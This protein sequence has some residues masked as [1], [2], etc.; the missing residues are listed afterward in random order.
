MMA[1]LAIFV[2]GGYLDKLCE[3]EF[4][5]ARIAFDK[6][7]HVMTEI[8]AAKSTEPID[9]LRTLYY[10]CPPYQSNPPTPEERER[11]A[12]FRTWADALKNIDRFDFREGRLALRGYDKD[13]GQPIFQQKRVDLLLGLDFALLAGKQRVTHV[14]LLTGDSDLVP[15]VQVAKQEGVTTWL[16]HGPRVSKVR[17]QPT[18]SAELRQEVDERHEIDSAFIDQVRR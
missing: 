13:T 4:D 7:S 5:R 3:N 6:L 2:D 17:D 12:K 8:V 16:F 9:L 10:H 1:R 18:F 15:A 14:A 11:T